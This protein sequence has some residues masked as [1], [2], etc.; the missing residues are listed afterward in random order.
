MCCLFLF[1]LLKG[2]K[3]F[4]V[5]QRRFGGGLGWRCVCVFVCVCRVLGV[6]RVWGWVKWRLKWGVLRTEDEGVGKGITSVV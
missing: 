1:C 5:L 4:V 6:Y 2:L 3:S